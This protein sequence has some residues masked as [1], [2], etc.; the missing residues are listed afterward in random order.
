MSVPLTTVTR[1]RLSEAVLWEDIDLLR[2]IF[3]K[4]G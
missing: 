3:P 2:C 1:P 4:G